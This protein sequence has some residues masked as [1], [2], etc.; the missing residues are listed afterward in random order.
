[1]PSALESLDSLL[2]EFRHAVSTDDLEVLGRLNE[3]IQPTVQAAVDDMRTGNAS[4]SALEERLLDLQSLTEQASRGAREARDEA[5][6]G[7]REV[8]QNRSAVNAY[9][10]IRSRGS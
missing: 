7:L 8:N 5:A 9:A 2:D 10:N 3:A 4:A 1:M 6:K